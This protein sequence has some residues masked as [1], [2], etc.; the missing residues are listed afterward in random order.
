MTRTAFRFVDAYRATPGASP[1]HD[2]QYGWKNITAVGLPRSFPGVTDP[3]T[4]RAPCAGAASAAT[5]AAV[6]A[7]SNSRRTEERRIRRPSRTIP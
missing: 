6:A 3:F 4:T 1:W 2:V 7:T 5:S